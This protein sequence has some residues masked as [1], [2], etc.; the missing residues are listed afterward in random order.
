MLK[1]KADPLFVKDLKRL[2]KDLKI[3]FNE[4]LERWDIFYRNPDN[5]ELFH[6]LRIQQ[7]DGSYRLPDARD[8]FKLRKMDAK[9]R[10]LTGVGLWKDMQE[11]NQRL[12]MKYVE[13]GREKQRD[14]NKEHRTL[15]KKA[16]ENA[17][18]GIY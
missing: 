16:I 11:Y 18:R 2:S 15:W 10:N 9:T 13:E 8:I 7:D 6:V 1:P 3:E 17:Q 12:R 5:L 14:W 4:S